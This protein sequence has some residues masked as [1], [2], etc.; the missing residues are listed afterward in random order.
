MDTVLKP[1]VSKHDM[2][3]HYI[4]VTNPYEGQ[5]KIKFTKFSFSPDHTENT[6]ICSL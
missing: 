1:L 6:M 2:T 4:Q 3:L 5:K